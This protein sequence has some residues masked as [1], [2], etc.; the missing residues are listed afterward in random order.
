MRRLWG[1]LILAIGFA[2]GAVWGMDKGRK[3]ED[4]RI[5][6]EQREQRALEDRV[7]EAICKAQIYEAIIQERIRLTGK[8]NPAPLDQVNEIEEDDKENH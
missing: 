5:T 8:P 6:L 4:R 3:M 2:A 7:N 1:V